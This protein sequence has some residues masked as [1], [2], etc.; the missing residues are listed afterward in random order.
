MTSRV[1]VAG[2]VFV[3]R[4]IAAQRRSALLAGTKVHPPAAD[5]DA[6]FAHVFS[7]LFD[8][9]DRADVSTRG[10]GRHESIVPP[11]AT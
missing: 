5:L 10:I 9:C 2:R 11:V 7:G 3:R 4:A 6:L 1:S 8:R